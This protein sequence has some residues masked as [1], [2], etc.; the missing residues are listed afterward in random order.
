MDPEAILL[1]I[2]LHDLQHNRI[3]M[4]VRTIVAMKD[5]TGAEKLGEGAR[6]TISTVD[7]KRLAVL[8]SCEEVR[9]RIAA[10]Q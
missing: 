2:Q 3:D 9:K 8:E 5:Q 1:M 7:G 10:R 6:C 4:N